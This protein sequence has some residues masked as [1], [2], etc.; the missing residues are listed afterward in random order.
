[1]SYLVREEKAVD[2]NKNAAGL[3]HAKDGQS[4]E[5]RSVEIDSDPISPPNTG[6]P[7]TFSESGDLF[8]C[9]LKGKAI[10]SYLP[11]PLDPGNET[12]LVCN[13]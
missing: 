11:A 10:V 13:M 2:W 8:C 9:C 12:A 1:M 7:K 3:G 6:L 4:L 5:N